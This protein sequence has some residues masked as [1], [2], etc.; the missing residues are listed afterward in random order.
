MPPGPVRVLHHDHNRGLSAARNTG[1][2]AAT[3][4]WIGFLDAADYFTEHGLARQVDAA[5]AEGAD[6]TH[7]NTYVTPPPRPRA[8]C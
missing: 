1:V 7:A 3:G 4:G 6:I 5:R 8:M 2:A